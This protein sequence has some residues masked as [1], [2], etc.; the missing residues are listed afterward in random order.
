MVASNQNSV[1]SS[2]A[3]QYSDQ[4]CNPTGK[5]SRVDTVV[6]SE[7]D[8]ID[9]ESDVVQ[10]SDILVPQRIKV[11]LIASTK[12]GVIEELIDVLCKDGQISDRDQVLQ[13]VLDREKTRTTGIGSGLAIPHGKTTCAKDLVMAVGVCQEPVDFDSIDN[14]PVKL[15]ILLVSPMQMTGPH[16]QALAKISRLMS[17]ESLRRSIMAATSAQELYDTITQQQQ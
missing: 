16:I 14:N 3:S 2:P 15:V 9:R 11:P 7:V 5:W 8:F 13:A 10:I 12:Q 6:G 17:F 4:S 1:A